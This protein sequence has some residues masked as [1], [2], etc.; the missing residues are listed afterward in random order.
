M[1]VDL[2]LYHPY[3]RLVAVLD[4]LPRLYLAYLLRVAAVIVVVLRPFP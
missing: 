2:H 3:L 1:V 4:E